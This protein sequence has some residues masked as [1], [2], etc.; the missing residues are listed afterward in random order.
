M[1]VYVLTSDYNSKAEVAVFSN[2]IRALAY[3]N[4][5]IGEKWTKRGMNVDI[6][7]IYDGYQVLITDSHDE[8]IATYF[9]LGREI[10]KPC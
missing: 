9:I 3:V 4:Q 5:T 1:K 8:L 10:D 2:H 6:A 7:R